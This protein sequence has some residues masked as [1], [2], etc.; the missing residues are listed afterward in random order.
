MQSKI[1]K[2]AKSQTNPVTWESKVPHKDRL[3]QH[4]LTRKAQRAVV[5][6]TVQTGRVR[7]R[8]NNGV[9]EWRRWDTSVLI[10]HGHACECACMQPTWFLLTL[11]DALQLIRVQNESLQASERTCGCLSGI[12]D[13]CHSE[14]SLWLLKNPLFK[15]WAGVMFSFLLIQSKNIKIRCWM[16]Y[17]ISRIWPV[18]KHKNW[19]FYVTTEPWT[20]HKKGILWPQF[21]FLSTQM[22]TLY[23][24]LSILWPQI[25][26]I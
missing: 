12:G 21:S 1:K 4:S 26:Q 5:R 2:K 14:S 13:C 9:Y 20:G 23:A 8:T 6:F 19:L 7:I 15:Q 18:V 17:K 16:L 3:S 25:F 10:E 22:T 24:Q 11:L